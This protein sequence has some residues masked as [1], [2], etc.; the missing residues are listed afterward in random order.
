MILDNHLGMR[1]MFQGT[2]HHLPESVFRLMH[3]AGFDFLLVGIESGSDVQLKRFGKPARSKQLAAAVQRAK[4]AHIV[5]FG[6]FVHGG[7]GETDEDFAETV[8]FIRE[9]KPHAA[10]GEG[11]WLHSGSPLWDELVGTAGAEN[12]EGTRPKALYKLPGQPDRETLERRIGEFQKALAKSW[13]HWTRVL[14]IVDLFIHNEVFRYTALRL[15][16]SI[17]SWRQLFR[18]GPK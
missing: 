7:P 3:E 2:I 4:N 13:L 9:V 18:G 17:G 1:F 5:V 12:L 16:W 14:E 11:L 15:T 8:R 6:Y 10:G